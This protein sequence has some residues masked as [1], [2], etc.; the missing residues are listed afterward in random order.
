MSVCASLSS[1]D[2]V[3]YLPVTTMLSLRY[4]PIHLVEKLHTLTLQLKS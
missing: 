3:R 2:Y 1:P 4:L